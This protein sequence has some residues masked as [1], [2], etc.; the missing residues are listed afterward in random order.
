[1][2]WL[3]FVMFFGVIAVLLCG[4]PVAFSLAGVALLFAA[5]GNFVGGFDS[6]LMQALPSRIYGIMTNQIL[7]Q[8]RYLYLWAWF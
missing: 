5:L 3:A 6:S 7:M 1:M 4:F 8:Y 2:E